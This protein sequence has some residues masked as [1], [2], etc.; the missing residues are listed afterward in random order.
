MEC[1]TSTQ[2]A[3]AVKLGAL[4][5]AFLPM[6]AHGELIQIDFSS[7]SPGE[8]VTDQFD[9]VTFS[10]TGGAPI[11]GPLVVNPGSVQDAGSGGNLITPTDQVNP[12]CC[13]QPFF[14]IQLDFSSPIDFFSILA[15][16]AEIGEA[17]RLSAYLGGNLVV[18]PFSTS[19]IGNFS[20]PT[21]SGPIR[22]NLL[23]SLG[24]AVFDRVLIDLTNND[25]PEVWDDIRFN[26]VSVP[27][28][29]TLGLF[30]IG[31]FALIFM[32]RKQIPV[33]D[34]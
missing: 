8:V 20:I 23:G 6:I 29:G 14:D 12:V 27:E 5:V 22:E 18:L 2:R 33:R 31:L 24:G 3:A 19:V 15:L 34:I 26:V 17:Y 25:G 10:L 9:G 32:R 30:G 28:P 11:A 1:K 13:V 16:D 4:F 7:L 21:S